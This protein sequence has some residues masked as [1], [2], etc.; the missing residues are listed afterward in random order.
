MSSPS[1]YSTGLL[2]YFQ[3]TLQSGW[4][5]L[6]TNSSQ[7]SLQTNRLHSFVSY[8]HLLQRS[9]KKQSEN[10]WYCPKLARNVSQHTCICTV[11]QVSW[12]P[13]SSK[14]GENM[15]F[16]TTGEYWIETGLEMTEPISVTGRRGSHIFSRQSA[17]RW[18]LGCQP[19]APAALYPQQDSWYSFLLE[20]ESTLWPYCGWKN[21]VN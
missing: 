5:E 4:R 2:D 10:F 1:A 3:H 18:R 6:K 20:A 9:Y 17:H 16:I 14:S 12:T 15:N 13:G 19:Y 7:K 21:K 11:M 8:V